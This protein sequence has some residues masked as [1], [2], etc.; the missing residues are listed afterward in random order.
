MK[1]DFLFFCEAG[2]DGCRKQCQGVSF[3][4]PALG[5]RVRMRNVGRDLSP[6]SS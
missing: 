2:L 6:T 4:A 1:I 5:L 3:E